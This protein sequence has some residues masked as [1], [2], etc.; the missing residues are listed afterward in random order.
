MKR[1]LTTCFLVLLSNLWIWPL[2]P[3]F[4][5]SSDSS[6]SVQRSA[7]LV[8][9][10][11]QFDPA[12]GFLIASG[13]VLVFR[14]SQI[15]ATE[16]L[17]Y[18]QRNR[19]LSIPGPMTLTDGAKI[20]TR[21][22][23]AELD[24]DLRKGLIAGAEV[25]IS[26]QLQLVSNRILRQNGRYNVLDRVAASSCHVCTINPVPFWKIRAKRVIHDELTEQLY[27]EGAILELVG[28]PI[29]Y[30]PNL[31]V[32]DPNVTRA[33][34]F[35]V[36]KFSTLNTLGNGVEIPHYWT[37]GEHADLTLTALAYDKGSFLLHPEYRREIKNGHFSIDGYFTLADSLTHRS[38]RS[39][40]HSDGLFLLPREIELEFGVEAASDDNFRDDYDIG[41]EGEDRLTSFLTLNRT[42]KNSFAS[43]S[44]SYIQSLRSN[45]ID[46]EIPLVLPEVFAR[47]TWKDP[48]IGGKFG[49]NAQSLILLREDHSEFA[50]IGL[51][52]DWRKDWHL[53]NG[54][55]VGTYTRVAQNSYHTKGFSGVSD[56]SVTKVTP[57]AA[58]DLRLPLA[59]KK[60]FVTHII[61][62]RVQVVW[63][64]DRARMNR[65]EDS[66]QLE[67]EQTNLFSYNRFPG[68]DAS[69]RGLRANVGTSY[70]RYDS[71]GWTYGITLGRVLRAKNL[72]Q[73]GE[74]S[75]LSGTHSDYLTT[76][77]FSYLDQVDVVNRTSYDDDFRVGKNEL[78][79]YADFNRISS[80]ATYVWLEQDVSAG[81]T[82]PT[83]EI[84]WDMKYRQNKFWTHSARWRNNLETGNSTSGGFG[85]RYENECVAVNLSLSLQ[86]EGSG[87]VRPTREVGLTVELAGLGN[88]KRNK[89]YAHRCAALGG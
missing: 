74:G 79:I 33:S 18:D 58:L 46:T 22:Q 85:V 32:P 68:Q 65:N 26:Q 25:L 37:L 39:S 60:Q 73:F 83:H 5:Q 23:G 57:T 76:L 72:N 41:T 14:G 34:G 8:A 87:I 82:D 45:E 71:K 80:E 62:P 67:F 21:A 11:L 20:V 78:H 48:L 28:I 2:W 55:A 38:V 69:E 84:S 51:T 89:K 53:R 64:P 15:L 81:A 59:Y 40:L 49:L 86:Y 24:N 88:K 61:A 77:N 13:N 10:D 70:T 36:P 75:G 17:I 4:A 1:F 54:I 19:H 52:S 50:R 7:S 3:A 56:S 30:T 47:K 66:L 43:I 35:L 63:S 12:T 42:R 16:R 6:R 29:F 31:R 27:F 9:D 44:T